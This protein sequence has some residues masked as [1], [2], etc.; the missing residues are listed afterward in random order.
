MSSDPTQP[1][2]VPFIALADKCARALRNDMLVS[3][4]QRGFTEIA[5][6]HNAV[7]ATLP[8]E[9]ARAADMAA[10]AGVTRQSLGEV[11]RDMTRIGVLETIPDPNDG[12]AKIVRYTDYGRTVA[13]GGKNHIME[14]EQFFRAEFGAEDWETTRRVLARV[15][16]LLEPDGPVEPTPASIQFSG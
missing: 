1:D 8:S 7:F 12:R 6:S 4:H 10:R 13:A 2:F 3:G 5:S 9:G 11:I 14:R 16:E 15:R